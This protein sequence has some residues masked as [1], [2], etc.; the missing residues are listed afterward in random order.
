[1]KCPHCHAN[2]ADRDYCIRCGYM[3]NGRVIGEYNPVDKD[4]DLKAYQDHYEEMLWNTKLFKPFF[5]GCFYF[6]WNRHLFVGLVSGFIGLAL[7]YLLMLLFVSFPLLDNIPLNEVQQASTFLL[8]VAA[9]IIIRTIYAAIANMICLSLDR[10]KISY[11]K[12]K[13]PEEYMKKLLKQKPRSFMQ[14]LMHV[15]LYML[16]FVLFLILARVF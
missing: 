8:S 15:M 10:K 2:M 3:K 1:M 12:K 6:S 16:F 5:L 11:M 13:Y 14:V 4:S 9:I 7:Y